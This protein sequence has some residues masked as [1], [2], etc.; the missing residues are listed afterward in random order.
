[1][2]RRTTDEVVKRKIPQRV[3][4]SVRRV[5]ALLSIGLSG[6]ACATGSRPPVESPPRV[7]D[8]APERSAALRAA[9]G[10]LR[11]E[12]EADRWGIEAA[13]ERQTSSDPKGEPSSVSVP[14]SRGDLQ[15]QPPLPKEVP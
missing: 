9:S 8:S 5:A 3:Y 15:V 14:S 10:S 4:Y 11:L 2:L 1:M 13:R 7:K 12:E 6:L